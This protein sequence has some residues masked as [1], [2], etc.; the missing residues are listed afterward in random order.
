[1]ERKKWFG[2][3][4]ETES[5]VK[6]Q[7]MGRDLMPMYGLCRDAVNTVRKPLMVTTDPF[8]PRVSGVFLSTLYSVIHLTS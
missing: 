4:N 2:V 7:P 3:L 8:L 1:M 5:K 6:G